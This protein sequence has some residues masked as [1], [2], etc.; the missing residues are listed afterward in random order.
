MS[1]SRLLLAIGVVIVAVGIGGF[2]VY[3]QVLRG[4]SAAA[5]TLPRPPAS[6]AA[7]AAGAARGRASAARPRRSRAPWPAPGPSPPTASPATASAS[8]WPTCRP[9]ATRSGGPTR[10]PARSRSRRRATTT[11]LT[12][13][14]ADRRHDLDRLGQV[15]AR[16]PPAQ[17]GPPDRQLPDRDVH[18]DR[19]RSRSRRRA[20]RDAVGRHPD[21]RPDPPRRHEVGPDPGQGAARQRHD[22]GRGLARASRSRTTRSTAPEHRRVHRL[23][24][25]H[26]H[27]RVPGQLHQGLTTARRRADGPALLRVDAARVELLADQ[28]QLVVG[29]GRRRGKVRARSPRPSRSSSRTPSTVAPGWSESSRISPASS[30][31]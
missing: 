7:T 13:G 28:P 21:R 11:T 31:W 3:D 23:D 19:S 10:S 1:R 2:I 29:R 27:A 30:K 14:D 9:R 17:R 24:R 26:R 6:R 20:G 22:P 8:S 5:L 16:Q 12:A 15:A 18:A 4:D 25:R